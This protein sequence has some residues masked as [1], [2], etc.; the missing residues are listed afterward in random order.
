MGVSLSPKIDIFIYNFFIFILV[1]HSV[2]FH[3]EDFTE[4]L[5]LIN[6]FSGAAESYQ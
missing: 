6:L 1:S 4:I 5:L 2:S 3:F